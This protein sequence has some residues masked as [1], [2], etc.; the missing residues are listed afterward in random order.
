MSVHSVMDI[1][2]MIHNTKWYA[3]PIKQQKDI[4][5]GTQDLNYYTIGPF[6]NLNYER[7]DD[8]SCTLMKIACR[9]LNINPFLYFKISK[10]IYLFIM[11]FERFL[12]LNSVKIGISYQIIHDD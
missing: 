11:I 1:D 8:V 7:F 2:I 3:L 4:A 10:Q 9:L 5:H 12:R 6:G